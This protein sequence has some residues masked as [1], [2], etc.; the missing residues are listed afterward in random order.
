MK[1]SAEQ[2]RAIDIRDTNVVVSASAGSGKT[3]VLV[4]R[5]SQLVLKDGYPVDQILAMTFTN[6]A[7]AEMKAR[8]RM[9]LLEEPQTDFIKRQLALL[10][11]AN[12]CTIDSFCLSIVQNY[13]YQIPISYTMANQIASPAQTSDAFAKGYQ[14]ALEIV[15]P[16]HWNHYASV[17]KLSDETIQ[18][19]VQSCIQVA[20]AKP[21]PKEWFAN[22][23]EKKMAGPLQSWFFHTFK[24]HFEAMKDVCQEALDI[25]DIFTT[26]IELLNACIEDCQ[27]QDYRS[28]YA[29]FQT[30]I[31]QTAYVSTRGVDDKDRLKEVNDKLRPLEKEVASILLEP[32]MY[33]ESTSFMNAVRDE[34]CDLC[35]ETKHR[36]D[37]I[38]RKLE[39]ID[40]SDM[41]SYAYQL[42]Q[43]PMIR[44]ELTEKFDAILIDE[45][46]DTNDLQESIIRCIAREDNV[47]RVGDIKQSIYGFRQAKPDIMRAHMKMNDATHTT[48]A[49]DKNFRSNESIIHFNNDFYSKIMNGPLVGKQFEEI[50]YAHTGAAYQRE[51]QQY[52]VRFL[53]TES[54]RWAEEND[55][56]KNTARSLH[57]QNKLDLIAHDIQKHHENGV[58][59]KDICILSRNHSVQKEIT[60]TLEAYGI[61]VASDLNTGYYQNSAVQI[62]VA[63]MQSFFTP[64]DDIALTAS[65]L[66]PLFQ[67]TSE[68]LAQAC[69]NKEKHVSLYQHLKNTSL[70]EEWRALRASMYK[71][72]SQMCI[73][74]YMHRDFYQASCS[75]QDR[76]NLD[77][78]LELAV[79]QKDGRVFVEQLT[80]DAKM[81][82]VAQAFPYGKEDDVVQVKT[83]HHSKGLQYPVV[84]IYSTT[85]Q[86]NPDASSPISIDPELGIGFTNL[87][88]DGAIKATSMAK[89]AIDAKT[90][91]DTI[92][93]EMRIF[94]VAT[95]RAQKELIF[96][97]TIQSEEQYQS[98]LNTYVLSSG[99]GYS[100]WVLHTYLNDPHSLVIFEKYRALY[101]RPPLQRKSA[102]LTEVRLY[103][104]EDRAF[105]SATASATKVHQEWKAFDLKRSLATNRGTMFHEIMALAYPYQRADCVE[106]SNRFQ[107]TLSNTDWKQIESLNH[108]VLYQGWMDEKHQFE[109][110]Y[111]LEQEGVCIHGF[112]DFVAWTK[113]ETIIVD[114][115]TDHVES[116]EELK[117]RYCSQLETYASAMRAIDGSK[118]VR[119]YI[120]S[121]YFGEMIEI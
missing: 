114:F 31:A 93:E 91:L 41:E 112:M 62:I 8:L 60:D 56:N 102:S 28:L 117:Q 98:P 12:I 59:Y 16:T 9:R 38:K 43:I 66:S 35:M 2:Q 7:A 86:K 10:E 11:T 101:E 46:Q 1:F 75:I 106:L 34:F 13:Y 67:V 32:K 70:M 37:V 100:S 71:D 78:L 82:S 30:Y 3:S 104:G 94:Y 26:K 119:T 80:K 115:K 73:D 33:E 97:D 29:R 89:L 76:T 81:D 14:K 72:V 15:N 65:L 88:F 85:K 61:P 63:T 58:A 23:K 20:W 36:F 39:I 18:K 50:D 95:T 4:E 116:I 48:L 53:Y 110:S 96:V 84:Y 49:M 111:I 92:Q 118:P 121:F 107:Y 45:F 42:L 47:F 54:D 120:Y 87:L 5:L 64:N 90:K 99:A 55:M 109:C 51:S 113:D 74:L 17:F 57:K 24:V 22:I 77:Y 108:N 105:E 27:K 25:V 21:N 83:M 40:F 103:Q 52:P 44:Q 68:Q 69:V 19:K 6:D 79:D